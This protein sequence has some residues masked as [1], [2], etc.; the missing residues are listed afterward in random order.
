MPR[1]AAFWS[2]SVLE[3]HSYE[4]AFELAK[5][6]IQERDLGELAIRAGVDYRQGVLVVP[7]L[8]REC[9]VR[10]GQET[11]EVLDEKGDEAPVWLAIVVLHYLLTATGEQLTGK[12]A[13][14]RQLVGGEAYLSVFSARA[15]NRLVRSFGNDA[16]SLLKVGLALGGKELDRGD[17]A[18]E[19]P[20]LPRVPVTLILWEGDDEFPPNANIVFDSSINGYLPTEDVV[21]ICQELVTL[22]QSEVETNGQVHRR[23]R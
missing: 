2:E 6:D 21:V 1:L 8:N 17:V 20:V 3:T 18:L 22:L 5:T 12:L 14:F 15:V 13:D 7:F 16:A 11:V 23:G 10:V 9:T 4:F 19:M